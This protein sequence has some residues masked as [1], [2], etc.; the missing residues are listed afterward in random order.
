MTTRVPEFQ[1]T[2]MP[3]LQDD[4]ILASLAI[5]EEFLNESAE[6]MF[7]P[8]FFEQIG[9]ELRRLHARLRIHHGADQLAATQADAEVPPE[10]AEE[11]SRLRAEHSV[12]IGILDR[13]IRQVDSVGDRSLEAK[14]VFILRGRELIACL[15][16]HE[17]E[18]DRLLYLSVWCDTGGES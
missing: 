14:E 5:V 2:N 15:R 1:S 18:E 11:L 4:S 3:P 6:R 9:R 17:A 7:D 10:L 8:E 13:L 12:I 16:R